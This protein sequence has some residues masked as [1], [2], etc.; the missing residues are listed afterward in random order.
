MADYKQ[1]DLTISTY[2]RLFNGEGKNGDGIATD[3][4]ELPLSLIDDFPNNP[5]KVREDEDMEVLV[6]SIRT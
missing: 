1:S 3:V 5:Y 2:E 4:Y 6:D